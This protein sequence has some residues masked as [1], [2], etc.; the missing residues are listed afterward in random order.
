MTCERPDEEPLL[1]SRCL[2]FH[3]ICQRLW[4]PKSLLGPGSQALKKKALPKAR[5][6]SKTVIPVLRKLLGEKLSFLQLDFIQALHDFDFR[7]AILRTTLEPLLS[8]KDEHVQF[9]AQL[10][11]KTFHESR[12][13][14]ETKK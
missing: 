7:Q 11:L 4:L 6:R 3:R 5:A 1:S 12:K 2:L 8:H 13:G 10:T 14:E 9:L